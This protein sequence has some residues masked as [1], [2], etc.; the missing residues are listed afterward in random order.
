MSTDAAHPGRI[1][2]HLEPGQRLG[3]ARVPG[4]DLVLRVRSGDLSVELAPSV[5]GAVARASTL[6]VGTGDAV[7]LPRGTPFA[8]RAG[9]DGATLEVTARPPGPEV[10]VG[11]AARRPGPPLAALVA[12]AVEQGVELLP[13]GSHAAGE[14][15]DRAR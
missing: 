13:T 1:A 5:P 7:P 2:V 4:A 12:A 15:E 14:A 11:L 6:R 3:P 8:V 10:F 9:E